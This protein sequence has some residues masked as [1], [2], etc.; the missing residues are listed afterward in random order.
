METTTG[1]SA[2]IKKLTQQDRVIV[3]GWPSLEEL[4]ASPAAAELVASMKATTAAR[5][6][7]SQPEGA[8]AA[9]ADTAA[10][11]VSDPYFGIKVARIQRVMD[12]KG[13]NANISAK[14]AEVK[15][16]GVPTKFVKDGKE[17]TKMVLTEADE[18]LVKEY[19]GLRVRFG[20]G[21]GELMQ[22]ICD[23]V[24]NDLLHTAFI[25]AIAADRKIV[26]ID[27][28]F[29][30]NENVA[31][32]CDFYPVFSHLK[33]YEKERE[34]FLAEERRNLVTTAIEKTLGQFSH[35]SD[36]KAVAKIST[37][38]DGLKIYAEERAKIKSADSPAEQDE[39]ADDDQKGLSFIFYIAHIVRLIRKTDDKFADMRTSGEFVQFV[40]KIVLELLA[41]VAARGL[42]YLRAIGAITITEHN[43]YLIIESMF[44]NGDDIHER[45][46]KRMDNGKLALGEMS[47]HSKLGEMVKA[48]VKVA[49]EPRK[50]KKDAAE[51][52]AAEAPAAEAATTPTPAEAPAAVPLVVVSTPA[53]P[54][55]VPAAVTAATAAAATTAAAAAATTAAPQFKRPTKK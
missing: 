46:V 35:V 13:I 4:R 29:A 27:H 8:A 43:L 21:A 44:A 16:R 5:A 52:P 42:I 30:N 53:V 25:N 41:L 51:A 40:N 7:K 3:P 20:R 38:R 37:I 2:I 26:G 34:E 50:P 9:A 15:K 18:A 12:K 31:K 10:E 11:N 48:P 47:F 33:T 36:K 23:E 17:I 55:S 45:K 24:V 22:K 28:I 6:A 1:I 14:I 54:T 49:R 32:A 39:S 19:R